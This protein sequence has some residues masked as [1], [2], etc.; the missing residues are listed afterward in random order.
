MI[1]L[2]IDKAKYSGEK[3]NFDYKLT[4]FLDLCSKANVL[5]DG[6]S[7]AYSTMLRRLALNHYYT[8]LK[9][10]PLSVS[11]NQLCNATRNY[12]KGPEYKRGILKQ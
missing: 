10:N 6:L 7:Q 9:N 2:Y 4:I 1:K 3:D 8:N 12:F 11:F 5:Q